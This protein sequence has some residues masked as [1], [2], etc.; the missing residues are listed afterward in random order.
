M[1]GLAEALE[2]REII[3]NLKRIREILESGIAKE[4]ESTDACGEE[5]TQDWIPITEPP[6][7]EGYYL[8]STIH[9]QVYVDYWNEDHFERTE[10]VL[11]WMPR[12]QPYRI[13]GGN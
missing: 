9:E 6:E 4:I 13:Q 3:E 11:A 8:I 10:T 12:P 2:Q 1:R 7:T 5:K